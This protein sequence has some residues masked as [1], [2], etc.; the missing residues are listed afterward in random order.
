VLE[1]IYKFIHHEGSPVRA[2]QKYKYK[3]KKTDNHKEDR[4]SR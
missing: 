2:K 1:N 4:Q 3:Y